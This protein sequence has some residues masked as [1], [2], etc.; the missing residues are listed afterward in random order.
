MTIKGYK[1]HCQNS[2]ES[3]NF[4]LATPWLDKY[5]HNSAT[6]LQSIISLGKVRL[7]II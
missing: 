7:V 3:Y 2:S 1:N 5:G 4:L 6:C